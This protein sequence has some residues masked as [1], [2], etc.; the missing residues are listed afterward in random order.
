MTDTARGTMHGSC[1]PRISSSAFSPV[2][3][4]TVRCF[5]EI[6]GVGFIAARKMI[7]IPSEMPP[8]IPPQLFAEHCLC[9]RTFNAVKHRLANS[10]R[11]TR[12]GTFD[13]AADTVL[14]ESCRFNLIA[15]IFFDAP[16]DQREGRKAETVHQLVVNLR[17]AEA[18]VADRAD[19]SDVCGNLY[20][21]LL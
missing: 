9:Y 8:R 12:H 16:V 18:A 10:D 14:L 11:H 2:C 21:A 5:C 19:R 17:R 1:L 15:H 13:A 6:D 3:K 4:L 20:A 7:G